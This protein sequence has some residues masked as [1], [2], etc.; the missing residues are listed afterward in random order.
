MMEQNQFAQLV[1]DMRN[2]QKEYFRTPAASYLAKKAAL[3]TSKRLEREVDAACN[4][5][6]HPGSNVKQVNLF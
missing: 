1:Q 5:I 6:L 3:E 4:A 2:A